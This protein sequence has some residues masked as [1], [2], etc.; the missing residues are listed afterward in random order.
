MKNRSFR[1]FA[2]GLLVLLK[3]IVVDDEALDGIM[4]KEADVLIFRY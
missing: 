3:A 2:A 4:L 1:N